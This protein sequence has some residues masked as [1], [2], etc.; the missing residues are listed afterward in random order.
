MLSHAVPTLSLPHL[1]RDLCR[2]SPLVMVVARQVEEQPRVT[3]KKGGT[4]VKKTSKLPDVMRRWWWWGEMWG[5][6]RIIQ[7]FIVRLSPIACRTG[8]IHLRPLSP[9]LYFQQGRRKP[10]RTL[11]LII[12][13][14]N[15]LFFPCA[16]KLNFD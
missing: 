7:L 13:H 5:Q 8:S 11:A 10:A 12:N 16:Y 2:G 14:N 15:L 4:Y 9:C 3:L 1:L 6:G